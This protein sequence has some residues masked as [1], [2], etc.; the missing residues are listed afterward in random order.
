MS[1]LSIAVAQDFQ[2]FQG[3]ITH[4]CGP[5]NGELQNVVGEVAEAWRPWP[6]P[7]PS[8]VSCVARERLPR[9]ALQLQDPIKE[10]RSRGVME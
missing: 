2:Q 6:W 8:G 9:K 4:V 7:V 3:C 5:G 10:G 1:V